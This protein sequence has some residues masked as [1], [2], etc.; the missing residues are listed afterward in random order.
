MN[1][2]ARPLS[3]D[4]IPRLHAANPN[5]TT[6]AMLWLGLCTG[7]RIGEIVALNVSDVLA[8]NGRLR[9]EISL[10]AGRISKNGRGRSIPVNPLLYVA[11]NAYFLATG[12]LDQH[13]ALF[14]SNRAGHPRISRRQA[15]RIVTAAFKR[16][17]LDGA[18][19]S[20]AL[21]K[22]FANSIHQAM[23]SD[24]AKTQ[25]AL[26]HTSPAS[27]IAYLASA[28]QT[29]RYAVKNLYLD[30]ILPDLPNFLTSPCPE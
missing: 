26:G 13:N 23:G 12:N 7:L 18:L 30:T 10:P 1:H 17:N 6:R 20:H 22:T 14:C 27:T 9:D 5:P 24:L 2:A 4:E 25:L 8:P 19:P 28:D 3:L 11:L 21:R 16:A 29:V 15:M